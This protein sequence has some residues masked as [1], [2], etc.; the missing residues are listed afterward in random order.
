MSNIEAFVL[1]VLVAYTPG[2]ILLAF[3]LCRAPLKYYEVQDLNRPYPDLGAAN[4][5]MARGPSKLSRVGSYDRG[6]PID[7]FDCEQKKK[8]GPEKNYYPS[9]ENKRRAR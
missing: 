6:D 2:L 7:H 5:Q 4:R 1:G 9:T 3:V 8:R